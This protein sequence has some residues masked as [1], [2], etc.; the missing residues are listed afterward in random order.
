MVTS[1]LDLA[2]PVTGLHHSPAFN[3]LDPT[4]K[5]WVNFS[6]GMIFAK[7]SALHLLDIP[8]LFHFKWYQRQNHVTM[9]PGGSTPDF[10][11]ESLPSGEYF[12]VEAK[13]RNSGF[14]QT[15]LGKAKEQ[16]QQA[17][18]VNGQ[19]CSLHVGTLLYRFSNG[20]IAM[21]MDDPAADERPR[22]ELTDTRE[23]WAEYYRT[24]W[25]L[26]QMN[27]RQEAAFRSLTGLS[28]EIHPQVKS[29]I[30]TI[31]NGNEESPWKEARDRLKNWIA[32]EDGE[33]WRVLEDDLPEMRTFPDGVKLTFRPPER[34]VRIGE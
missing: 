3:A 2:S 34:K 33:V 20:R 4:E 30:E 27:K 9:L 14:S 21:A 13:G 10:I 17:V 28:V 15:V 12:V 16:A 11:G 24:V 31:I 26:S 19:A 8:L 1:N 7:I 25:G 18:A 22:I 29:E 6:L 32:S 23:T 5:G